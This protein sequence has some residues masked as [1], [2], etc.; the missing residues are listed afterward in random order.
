MSIEEKEKLLR[1]LYLKTITNRSK[2]VANKLCGIQSFS[3]VSPNLNENVL[4][5]GLS[6]IKTKQ[7]ILGPLNVEKIKKSS[8]G[9]S[10]KYT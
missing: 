6:L 3:I 4:F 7:L 8:Y 2:A 9:Y 10:M 5:N 1:I